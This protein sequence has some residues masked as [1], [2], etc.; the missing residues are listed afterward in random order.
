[1]NRMLKLILTLLL[2]PVS[3]VVSAAWHE[4]QAQIMGTEI[5]VYLWHV[6]AVV[7]Q[8]AVTDV[9]AEF[10]R[11]DNLMS[12]YIE[13][14]ELSLVNRQ[15]ATQAVVVS[16]ELE[17]LITQSLAMSVRT[18]GA[19]DVT[20]A[21][22]GYLYDFRNAVRPEQ[23]AVDQQLEAINFRHIAVDQ[24]KNTIQ[25]SHPNVR[26]DLGGIAKGYAV[27]QAI[28]TLK[29]HA[30]EH[31]IVTAG[32]DTR[33]LGQHR[34]RPW[35]VGIQD[36]R[37][38][39]EVVAL[40]PLVDESIST[41]GDYERYFDESG[42]RYHHIIDPQT[43]DS[44]RLVR[45][46]SILGSESILTDALSTSVFVL[47]LEAGIKLIDSIEGYEAIVVDNHGKLHYSTGLQQ[48]DERPT[49]KPSQANAAP[50]KSN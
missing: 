28:G 40:I 27:D 3:G 43:G 20:Y 30:V 34:D 44:A 8:R 50:A 23:A 45:S 47:G 2:L 31:A 12:S 38:S 36:P 35:V 10:R 9:L 26:I 21:S 7:A 15:A 19:F 46:V 14:S 1:M 4:Q 25:F 42:I 24:D 22:V 18:Q 11:V 49:D 33:V 39:G 6:D 29:K 5:R 48:R 37:I 32:G 41:S 16:D 13:S 17:K